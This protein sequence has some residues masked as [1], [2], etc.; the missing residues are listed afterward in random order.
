MDLTAAA[1]EV[2]KHKSLVAKNIRNLVDTLLFRADIH[3]DSK[4]E[5]PEL[6]G[7]AQLTALMKDTE[8][9]SPEYKEQLDKLKPIIQHHQLNNRHHPEYFEQGVK[10]MD[11]I[12]I[13][14]MLCDWKAST[15]RNKNGDILKSIEINQQRFG[16]SDDVKQILLNTALLLDL[17]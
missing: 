6:S 15:L 8:Y 17:Y 4:L 14:E 7:F 10:G 16:Y 3:D 9:G 12:D 2:Y 1:L 11:L 5:E 13:I